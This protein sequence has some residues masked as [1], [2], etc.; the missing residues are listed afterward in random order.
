MTGWIKTTLGKLCVVTMGQSPPSSTYNTDKNGLPFFQGKAEFSDLYPVPKKWCSKPTK[1]A[2]NGSIL[3]SVRAPVGDVNIANQ[4]CCIGRG[5]A[6]IEYDACPRFIFYF[7]KHSKSELEKLSTGTTFKAIS[8]HTILNYSLF[9]PSLDL[10]H[11]IVAKIKE[12]FSELDNGIESLKKA[13]EQLKTYRQ[14]VL[15]YAFEGK[16]TKEWRG[17]KWKWINQRSS[18]RYR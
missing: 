9:I 13:R 5:L 2:E 12:L 18:S 7:L 1:K 15:K 10:Q 11:C 3:I 8:K 16:L 17:K 6:A 4:H 14:A